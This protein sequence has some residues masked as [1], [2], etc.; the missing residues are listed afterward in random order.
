MKRI[1]IPEVK[2][3]WRDLAFS[4]E[5]KIREVKAMEKDSQDCGERCSTL[6][7]DWLDT[8]HGCTPKTWQNLLERIKDVDELA[9]AAKS[10][11]QQLKARK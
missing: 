6:F 8:N 11:E 7:E 3:Y 2:A 10:I 4:M 1:V 5:Y 9:V